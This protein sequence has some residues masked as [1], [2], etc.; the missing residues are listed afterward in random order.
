VLSKTD[1]QNTEIRTAMMKLALIVWI[2][3]QWRRRK[4]YHCDDCGWEVLKTEAK[5]S[6]YASD[7]NYG[8][9]VHCGKCGKIIETFVRF[10]RDD[11]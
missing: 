5:I 10:W 11:E 1:K 3:E 8:R 9:H 4:Y 7:H 6:G 2:K